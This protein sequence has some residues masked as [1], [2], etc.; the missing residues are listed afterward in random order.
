MRMSSLGSIND[1]MGNAIVNHQVWWKMYRYMQLGVMKSLTAI[2]ECII[3]RC[4]K[5][6]KLI[7]LHNYSYVKATRIHLWKMYG[8]LHGCRTKL[9]LLRINKFRNEQYQRIHPSDWRICSA[10]KQKRNEM[11]HYM[12]DRIKQHFKTYSHTLGFKIRFNFRKC[13]YIYYRL[14]LFK[15]KYK[16]KNS[17]ENKY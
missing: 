11:R 4:F 5:F 13:I 17:Q 8:N 7:T 10:R 3:E 9:A 16:N 1:P 12:N 15:L 6:C 2:H 14:N